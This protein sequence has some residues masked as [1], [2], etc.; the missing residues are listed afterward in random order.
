MTQKGWLLLG[1]TPGVETVL[2]S[3]AQP[4][5]LRGAAPSGGVVAPEDFAGFDE[6]GFGKI[7]ISFR[8]DRYGSRASIMTVETRIRL[9]DPDSR[10][11]VL[12][13]W[14]MVGPFGQVIRWQAF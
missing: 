10:R 12:R 5:R 3:V 6:P 8:V 11:R 4:W 9:T 2:G 7:A 14:R 1:E 13:Y